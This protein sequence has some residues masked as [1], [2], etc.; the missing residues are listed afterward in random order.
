M[1]APDDHSLGIARNPPIKRYEFLLSLASTGH[2][3]FSVLATRESMAGSAKGQSP[4]PR[5]TL[6][7]FRAL[8]S[9]IAVTA[10]LATSVI[11]ISAAPA[12]AYNANSLG[13]VYQGVFAG[14]P[15]ECYN[16]RYTVPA[17]VNFVHITVS[18]QKGSAGPNG[19]NTG[20][21]GGLGGQV[22]VISAVTPGQVLYA[23]PSSSFERGFF[24][25]GAGRGGKASFVSTKDLASP[26]AANDP[27]Q[28]SASDILV[29]A[30]GGG[31]GGSGYQGTGG[32]GGNA[33]ANGSE[34]TP[35]GDNDQGDGGGGGG[36]TTTSHGAPGARGHSGTSYTQW[37]HS[38]EYFGGGA[39]GHD[40]SSG[41]IGG[42]V[43]AGAGG[44][45]G[46]GIFSGGGGGGGYA[47]G[48][49]G[50]GGA[51]NYVNPSIKSSAPD[52]TA[53]NSALTGVIENGTAADEIPM[54]TITPVYVPNP[55]TF[56]Y[57]EPEGAVDSNNSVTVNVTAGGQPVKFG[58]VDV[59]SLQYWAGAFET[60]TVA[61][62]VPVVNGKA[63]FTWVPRHQGSHNLI[64]KYSGYSSQEIQI[65][66]RETQSDNYTVGGAWQVPSVV[67]NPS[68][69]TV[70][71][72]Q[73]ATFT[74]T[75]DSLPKLATT[76]QSSDNGSTWTD[77]AD[78]T[79]TSFSVTQK[80]MYSYKMRYRAKFTNAQG[81]TY[82]NSA[83]LTLNK[84]PITVTPREATI[85]Y[86]NAKPTTWIVDYSTPGFSTA[87]F[88]FG[89]KAADHISGTNTCTTTPV[90][91]AVPAPGDYAVN[92]SGL[93]ST[94][95][96]ITNAPG[97]FHVEQGKQ[98]ITF[99][100]TA[101]EPK[102]GGTYQVTATGGASGNPVTFSRAASSENWCTVTSSGLVTFTSAYSMDGTGL[103]RIQADQA[104]DS[105]LPA[106]TATQDVT[107]TGIPP[108][109]TTTM[110]NHTINY[111]DPITL[112]ATASGSPA[113]YVSWEYSYDGGPSY[114]YVVD[115][116]ANSKQT[117][118]TIPKL[119]YSDQNVLVTAT[120]WNQQNRGNLV[121]T[122]SVITV[123]KGKLVVTPQSTSSTYGEEPVHE[124]AS[125]DYSG[126]IQGENRG[127]AFAY[128]VIP[129]C[130]PTTT[131]K[132]DAGTYPTSVKCTEGESRNYTLD[133]RAGSHTVNAA[134]LTV[135]AGEHTIAWGDDIGDVPL[136]YSGF[137]NDDTEADLDTPVT[138]KT[139]VRI[140]GVGDYDLYCAAG[141][142]RNY[143]IAE[144][145]Q[146]HQAK[147]T[148]HVVKAD[149]LI[150]ASSPTSVYGASPATPTPVYSGLASDDAADALTKAPV[151]TTTTTAKSHAGVYKDATT[152]SGA[153]SPNYTIAYAPGTATVTP[154]ALTAY[155]DNKG[156]TYGAAQPKLSVS[157]TG[158]LN[159]DT[160][161]SLT[162]T[163]D[164]SIPTARN[165]GTH[166][167]TCG[168]LTSNDYAITWT[169]GQ[170]TVSPAA[171]GITASATNSVYG[172]ARPAVEPI[173]TGLVAGDRAPATAPTC[174]TTV[175]PTTSVG[176][177]S[178][179]SSCSGAADSNYQFTY[180]RSSGTVTAAALTITAS[181]AATTYGDD[182]PTI[183]PSYNGFVNDQGAA[184]L[185]EAVVCEP[186]TK[187][188][189]D[190]G[191]YASTCDGA[192]D[193]NYTIDYEQGE[194]VIAPADLTVTASNSTSVYG[195]ASPTVTAAYDGLRAGDTAPAT[196]AE[197]ETTI[198][199][200]TIVG[201][202]PE[203]STCAKADDDNYDI[204]YVAG[205]GMVTAAPLTITASNG[206]AAYGAAAPVITPAFD[207]F[208]NDDKASDLDH[209]PSCV[210]N[211]SETTSVGSYVSTCAAASDHNYEIEYETGVVTIGAAPLVIT[212]SSLTTVYGQL[213][214]TVTPLYD[215][216]L[217]DDDASVLDDSPACVTTALPT[218]GAGVHAD[219]TSCAGAADDNY[220]IS[221][222]PGAVTVGPAAATITALDTSS[223]YGSAPVV[224][225]RYDGL[226]NGERE[227]D[228][229]RAATCTSS[230]DNSSTVG[231]Y[232]TTCA[233][234]SDGNY[235]FS[236]V[237][238]VASVTRAP[239]TVT[240][241]PST[242]VEATKNP[243]FAAKFAGLVNG[244]SA[245]SLR[246]LKYSTPA[247]AESGPGEYR[248]TASGLKAPNY[249]VTYKAGTLTVTAAAPVASAGSAADP[250]VKTDT[251]VG[252]DTEPDAGTQTDADADADTETDSDA[253][254]GTDA[255]AVTTHEEPT[256]APVDLTLLIWALGAIV[257]IGAGSATWAGIARRR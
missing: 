252:A 84:A 226:A 101:S 190:V 108:K 71:Y 41:E 7:S 59:T 156:S 244:D 242:R 127:D 181:D 114:Q 220:A 245:S 123:V 117:E 243:T 8:A 130:Y 200:A 161:A 9:G 225:S 257:L 194:V 231:S 77:I 151:C 81:S 39:G 64:A 28:F 86:G 45:G 75:G 33:G 175:G 14:V 221:Y 208:V 91:T 215:G 78:S 255:P 21:R 74:A 230:G 82:S 112:T 36:A 93:S 253:D 3:R 92:C 60:L 138:C 118:I 179:A 197:C 248:V 219:A 193:S 135:T 176:T 155:A 254:T 150:T 157:Y 40:K 186:N 80:A 51:A 142:D 160:S 195:A 23:A 13:P 85:P 47:G 73:P 218:T 144:D 174:T 35:G 153:T 189:T 217:N 209:A 106:T 1:D 107:V 206:K 29:L 170:Y 105:L 214:P 16:G 56:T 141:G 89:D 229:D 166:V 211:T 129:E 24:T 10:L 111:G 162:G 20:G 61:S 25:S 201:T 72:G 46:I 249:K 57:A 79:G 12:Q 212:A 184:D 38:G 199:P 65:Q 97:V 246:G 67:T 70:T 103:C 148:L 34:G 237:S 31:G 187:S 120:F 27:T 43:A 128:G 234:A 207:G 122:K 104:G 83:T 50:G 210:S 131:A 185:D 203:S 227:A 232:V 121:T 140:T 239:L 17:G 54:I 132:T 55:L 168:G 182:A 139:A 191:T 11:A 63:S 69:T 98:T 124:Q 247:T 256:N 30:G 222:V 137:V 163:A 52:P 18:G 48:S 5:T 224:A 2:T 216:W 102:T 183:K 133:V 147:T 4:M 49:G 88:Y 223:V 158:F 113:P 213:V 202:Y 90:M 238:G 152:C 251:D 164:C 94:N 119:Q 58:T 96:A 235:T 204:A 169:K 42:D 15:A 110:K 177:H 53:T 32:G 22:E 236:Y 134:P 44:G 228:L 159:G 154:A 136:T 233:D 62:N 198:E 188:G 241:V 167:I 66:P 37:A 149:L 126:F 76:W 180:A 165:A 205:V 178:N 196:P 109:I 115:P 250:D 125:L 95:Y 99:T 240:V 68:D 146:G 192:A 26:C 19:D 172:A 173:Y 6:P 100:S 171:L 143:T 116:F 145:G 87:Q